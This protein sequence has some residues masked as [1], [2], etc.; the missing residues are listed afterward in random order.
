MARG[1]HRD[2]GKRI[3]ATEL[4]VKGLTYAEIGQALGIS[5]QRAQQLVEPNRDVY[6]FVRTKAN[7]RCE[8]CGVAIING[9]LHHIQ[10]T[11]NTLENF[12]D[13]DNLRYLCVACHMRAHARPRPLGPELPKNEAAQ[14]LGRKGGL[15]RSEAKVR[16]AK[17]NGKKGGAPKKTGQEIVAEA[18]DK[19]TPRRMRK[20][21]KEIG[22]DT[23]P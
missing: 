3:E 9:Q 1:R 13:I 23:E 8:T 4:R 15:S 19:L 5:R 6:A 22:I 16:A 14:L 21:L 2:D 18:F 11:G 17:E 12:N 10:A 20:I 7:W